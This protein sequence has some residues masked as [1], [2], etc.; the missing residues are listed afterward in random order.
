MKVIRILLIE[1]NPG[2]ARLLQEM[3]KET[4]DIRFEVE[5]AEQLASGLDYL[6]HNFVDTVIL[7]LGL[8]D[9]QGLDSFREIYKQSPK[10]PVLVMT[11]LTDESI[12]IQ[13]MQEGAQDYLLKGTVNGKLLSRIIRFA[14]ER[15]QILDERDMLITHLREAMS[16]IKT[17][18]GLVPICSYCK[19]IRN[20]KGFW[21]QLEAYVSKHTGAEFNHGMCEECETK[22]YAEYAEFFK[23]RKK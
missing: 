13:A 20:D 6:K 11:G 14:M 21:E 5:T 7:D 22:A 18:K 1:D 3:L 10:V 9:S 12:G 17:L 15:K 8:P 2:D 16:K 23:D 4:A 19:K